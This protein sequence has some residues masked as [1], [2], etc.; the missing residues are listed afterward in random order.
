MRYI[1]ANPVLFRL[2]M[3]PGSLGETQRLINSF[4]EK[5]S[6][7]L[8]ET[9]ARNGTWQCPT[10]IRNTAMQFADQ[11]GFTE[12]P[13]LRYIAKEYRDLWQDA[14]QQYR[15]R[16]TPASRETLRRLNLLS[17]RLTRIQDEA[18]VK[19]MAGSDCGG[20]GSWV[21]PR[22]SLH[23]EFDLLASA[24]L[25]PLKVLQMATCNGAEFLNKLDTLGCV[26]EGRRA[27]LVVLD[28]N[29]LE[30][31]QNLHSSGVFCEMA[32]ITPRKD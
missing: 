1:I 23:Q 10:L 19:M 13:D 6:R 4:S 7:E 17:L 14:A 30:G 29:P 5:K 12:S 21:V 18:G 26:K 3:D 24:G 32:D 16:L 28:V 9:F 8:A 31:V 27:D 15:E 25:S 22:V 2:K 20:G 11:P